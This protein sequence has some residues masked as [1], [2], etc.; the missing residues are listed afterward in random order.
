MWDSVKAN[1]GQLMATAVVVLTVCAA[2]VEWRIV[3]NVDEKVRTEFVAQKVVS[4]SVVDANTESIKD[5][6]KGQDKIEGKL[7]KIVDILIE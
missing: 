3:Q 4:K 5:L 2:Y 6:E 7:D 1:W